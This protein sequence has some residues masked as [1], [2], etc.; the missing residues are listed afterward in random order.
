[1]KGDLLY[2]YGLVSILSYVPISSGVAIAI[3]VLKQ[4]YNKQKEN[5]ILTREN[6]NAELQIL[7]AQVH[8]HF[9]I[10]YT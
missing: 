8:P 3:K 9:L 7:K 2:W 5:Q 4:F 10:Q 6:A 1:M